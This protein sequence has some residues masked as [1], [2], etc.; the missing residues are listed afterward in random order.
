MVVFLG[1]KLRP[2]AKQNIRHLIRTGRL[3]C[4]MADVESRALYITPIV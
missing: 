4:T 3:K 2:V 1:G